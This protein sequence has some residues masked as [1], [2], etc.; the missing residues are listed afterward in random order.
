MSAEAY[1]KEGLASDPL[2]DWG[3]W[4]EESRAWEEGLQ[5]SSSCR[6]E[7]VAAA[8]LVTIEPMDQARINSKD[9]FTAGR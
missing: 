7:P 9:Q 8:S 6:Q 4:G 1:D 5:A 3:G 2:K